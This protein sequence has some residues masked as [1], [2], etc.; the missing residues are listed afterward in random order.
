MIVLLHKKS[1]Y[2][3]LYDDVKERVQGDMDQLYLEDTLSISYNGKTN[4][5][6]FT[7]NL[8]KFINLGR[9]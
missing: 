6:L 3:Y 5:L 8:R 2:L 9:L 4:M 7:L 1:G